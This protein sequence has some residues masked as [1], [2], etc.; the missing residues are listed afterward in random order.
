M[1]CVALGADPNRP[2]AKGMAPLG[3]AF[4]SPSPAL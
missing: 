1:G 2:G 4:L 3:P